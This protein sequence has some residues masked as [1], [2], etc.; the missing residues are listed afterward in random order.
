[1]DDEMEVIDVPLVGR[2]Y[3]WRSGR[4][5]SKLDRFCVDPKWNKTGVQDHSKV[6]MSSSP[7]RISRRCLR[8]NGGMR[9]EYWRQQSRDGYINDVDKNQGSE[10]WTG[11]RTLELTKTGRVLVR[12]NRSVFSRFTGSIL[13]FKR[14]VSNIDPD[15]DHGRF[16]VKSVRS[17]GPV[18]KTMI[19]IRR[20]E[21]MVE[22]IMMEEAKRI[23]GIPSAAADIKDAVISKILVARMRPLMGKLI[24]EAQIAFVQDRKI[25]DGAVIAC[26]SV[27]RLKKKKLQGVILSYISGRPMIL[28]LIKNS[29]LLVMVYGSPTNPFRMESTTRKSNNSVGIIDSQSVPKYFYRR[30]GCRHKGVTKLGV[31]N[32]YRR[33]PSRRY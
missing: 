12:S 15:C 6:W 2:K 11:H 16:M 7:I 3:T 17:A 24:G 26:E 32:F 33:S 19:K 31:A 5:A 13:V 29:S 14:T 28:G 27:A 9:A 23:E 21:D 10:N 20:M 25:L 18:F 22:K 4:V 30:P 1:M 8:K